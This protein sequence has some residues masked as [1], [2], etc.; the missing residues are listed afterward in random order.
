MVL[1]QC[2]CSYLAV[3]KVINSFRKVSDGD[4]DVNWWHIPEG[5]RV[6]KIIAHQNKKRYDYILL[7]AITF[8]RV[9]NHLSRKDALAEKTSAVL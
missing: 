6:C 5:K 1:E 9:C 7:G 2:W 3:W 4:E 8:T